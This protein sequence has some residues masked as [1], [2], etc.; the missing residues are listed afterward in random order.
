MSLVNETVQVQL[1]RAA[2]DNLH[3][4]FL[5]VNLPEDDKD[6]LGKLI[7]SISE[8]SKNILKYYHDI[9]YVVGRDEAI[10]KGCKAI[11]GIAMKLKERKQIVLVHKQLK[12]IRTNLNRL[13]ASIQVELAA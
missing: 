4:I 1:I 12:S 9:E 2:C 13:V 10:I 7:D 3:G 11:K 6:E 5:G 8:N